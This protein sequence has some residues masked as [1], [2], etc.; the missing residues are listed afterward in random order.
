MHG[1]LLWSTDDHC[2]CLQDHAFSTSL[3]EK[4]MLLLTKWCQRQILVISVSFIYSFVFM[5]VCMY[6][7]IYLCCLIRDRSS[8]IATDLLQAL[9]C[10]TTSHITTLGIGKLWIG[11]WVQRLILHFPVD[12]LFQKKKCSNTKT[13]Y[14]FVIKKS[15]CSV[16]KGKFCYN[17]RFHLIWVPFV[18]ILELLNK[19]KKG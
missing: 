11:V 18:S 3:M 16:P 12:Q 4:K 13:S 14:I 8:I 1:P 2:S 9:R 10:I 19:M 6:L 17:I 5:Y 7:F 15:Y